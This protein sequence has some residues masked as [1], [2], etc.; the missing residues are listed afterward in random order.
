MDY[1]NRN[2]TSN[3]TFQNQLYDNYEAMHRTAA[4]IQ[5]VLLI[6]VIIFII[7]IFLVFIGAITHHIRY[8]K[9]EDITINNLKCAD[10]LRGIHLKM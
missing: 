5:Y 1:N 3:L 9:E 8:R 6:T 7:I 10:I 4:P 2:S